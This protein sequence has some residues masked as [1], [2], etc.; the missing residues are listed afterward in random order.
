[1]G[2]VA[3]RRQK[4]AFSISMET[5]ILGN[6]LPD[7][8]TD[9]GGDR[10]RRVRLVTIAF[11]VL[12]AAGSASAQQQVPLPMQP[13]P[14]GPYKAVTITLPPRHSDASLEAFRKE[15]ADIA[16]K[17]DRAALAGKVVAK[18]FFW[19]RE[20]SNDADPKKSGID[21]LAAALGLDSPDGSG[22]QAL[23]NYAADATATP[24]PEMKGVICSPA[25]PS[26]NEEEMEKVAQSTR[27]DAS[28]WAYPTS[29]GVELRAKPEA[30]APVVEKL[31]MVM[32]RILLEET[33]SGEWLKL[34]APSGK[35]GYAAADLLTP[36]A[37]DQLCY[38]KEDSGWKIAG[39]IG[40]GPGQD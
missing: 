36:I 1:L 15:L 2:F 7:C 25:M 13:A 9:P 24:I 28:E 31:G 27:T 14:P 21:N 37:S 18:G 33:P 32:V 12:V 16:K 40:V 26:F 4:R 29:N 10:M 19:Q 22:W 35:V 20:D 39:Y 38:R 6:F 11:A 8:R 17:H 23:G 3:L 34:V 30:G 5:A